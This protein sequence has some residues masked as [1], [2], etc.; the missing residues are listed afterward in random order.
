MASGDGERIARMRLDKAKLGKY[1]K[2]GSY[3]EDG[4]GYNEILSKGLRRAEEQGLQKEEDG[5][6]IASNLVFTGIGKAMG[7][8]TVA[9]ESVSHTAREL[10]ASGADLVVKNLKEK[11]RIID[12]ILS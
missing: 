10:R 12:L 11:S 3:G 2:F 9:V 7:I 5:V 8:R 1:F 6:L 4:I